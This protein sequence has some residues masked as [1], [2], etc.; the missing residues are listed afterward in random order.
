LAAAI[1]DVTGDGVVMVD[2]D[3]QDPRHSI[4]E[5]LANHDQ[6]YDVLYA[7]NASREQH[8]NLRACYFLIY[9]IRVMPAQIRMPFD[10]GDFA[11]LVK[12]GRG[13]NRSDS[14]TTRRSGEFDIQIY[15]ISRSTGDSRPRPAMV[16]KSARVV[17]NQTHLNGVAWRPRSLTCQQA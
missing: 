5:L 15:S 6:G 4:L 11:L 14:P 8:G 2:A 16:P 3:L 1:H 17:G 7:Q 10:T 9:R 13:P 12:F